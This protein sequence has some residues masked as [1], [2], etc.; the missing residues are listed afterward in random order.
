MGSSMP[1][2]GGWRMSMMWMRMPGQSWAAAAALFLAMWAAM[3]I[4]MM[5][6][7]TMPMLLVFRRAAAFSGERH[8]AR[9]A[10]AMGAGYFGVWTLF[11]CMAYGIGIAI[12]QAAMQSLAV[13]RAVPLAIGGA[14][15]IAGVWQLTPW[16]TACLRHCRDPLEFVAHHLHGGASGAL[17]LGLHHGA[18]CAAC[19]WGLMLIQLAIGVMDLRLM[20]GV[21]AVIAAEKLL[22]RGATVAKIVGIGAVVSGLV[23]IGPTVMAMF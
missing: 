6:P 8:L 19:C 3:M 1:M 12:T 14:L 20:A 18:F 17:R 23:L 16:K 7:S 11:G 5:L 4:A 9:L 22:P 15:V 2:P 13:S 21:A 10:W